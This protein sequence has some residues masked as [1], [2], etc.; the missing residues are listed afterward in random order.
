MTWAQTRGGLWVPQKDLRKLQ[1]VDLFCGAGGFSCGFEAAGIDVVGAAE[2]DHGAACTYLYNL[3]SPRG[4]AV[5]YDSE[6]TRLKWMKALEK[7]RRR[8]K[9][10]LSRRVEPGDPKWI[11]AARPHPRQDMGCRGFFLGDVS[12]LTGEVMRTIMHAGGVRGDIDVVIGGPP[13]QGMSRANQRASATDPRNNLVLE[14][15]RLAD[16]LGAKVFIMEN[17]PPLVSEK[18]YRPLFESIVAR[19]HEAGFE[20]VVAQVVDAANYGVPQRRR[21]ALIVG[22]RAGI[23]FQFPM[24]SHWGFVS[25]AGEV[26]ADL[27]Q[28]E[29]EGEEAETE[30]REPGQLSLWGEP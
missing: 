15:V 11:G 5:G 26:A 9:D 30:N 22:T 24:P 23:P 2:W 8:R 27:N 29:E 6:E 16:E 19:A 7:G 13:C 21:R 18:K 1:A 3:G 10:A 20:K 25:K 28:E 17:V 12:Q 14:F 4:C